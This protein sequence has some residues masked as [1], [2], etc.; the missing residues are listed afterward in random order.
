MLRLGY[1]YARGRTPR[2]LAVEVHPRA[3][4]IEERD[5]SLV[6]VIIYTNMITYLSRHVKSFLVLLDAH[7]YTIYYSTVLFKEPS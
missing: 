4:A 2:P 7:Y 6:S 1:R 3:K 5:P